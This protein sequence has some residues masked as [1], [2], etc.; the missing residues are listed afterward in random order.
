MCKFLLKICEIGEGIEIRRT[1]NL[2]KIKKLPMRRKEYLR[3]K[4][5]MKEKIGKIFP[6]YIIESK[7]MNAKAP[8]VSILCGTNHIYISSSMYKK[9]TF[10]ERLAIIFHEIGHIVWPY[11]HVLSFLWFFLLIT[12][13]MWFIYHHSFVFIVFLLLS[14]IISLI[15]KRSEYFADKFA[16]EKIGGKYLLKA[17]KKSNEK[18]KKSLWKE[19]ILFWPFKTHPPI[20]ERIKLLTSK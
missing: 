4:R 17:L 2:L 5:I 18:V 10:R 9:L 8:L 1:F 7:E 15:N 14:R 20:E 11:K 3:I 16:K 19:I 13:S 6:I 12:P